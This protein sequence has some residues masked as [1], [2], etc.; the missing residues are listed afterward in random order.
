MEIE[1]DKGKIDKDKMEEATK[2]INGLI[3]YMEK[4]HVT[5][6]GYMQVNW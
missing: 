5:I 3:Q 2:N 4:Q 1:F 6:K